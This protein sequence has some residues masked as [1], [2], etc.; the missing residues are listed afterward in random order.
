MY[1]KGRQT[2]RNLVGVSAGDDRPIRDPHPEKDED[3]VGEC[4][5]FE[6]PSEGETHEN[7]ARPLSLRGDTRTG[8]EDLC[9]T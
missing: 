7:L 8:Y 2:R 6:M 9:D 4:L 5:G 3:E 1:P